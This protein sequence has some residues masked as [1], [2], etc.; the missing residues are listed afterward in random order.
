MLSDV[1]LRAHPSAPAI[2]DPY[3]S[4]IKVT[5]LLC[6]Y[7]KTFCACLK[8]KAPSDEKDKNSQ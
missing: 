7:K 8:L 1:R 2:T 3:L 4:I 5:G 6:I